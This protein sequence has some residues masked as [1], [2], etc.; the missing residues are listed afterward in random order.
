[1][2]ASKVIS[3]KFRHDNSSKKTLAYIGENLKMQKKF[4]YRN[5]EQYIVQQGKL[6]ADAF[7]KQYEENQKKRWSEMD[8]LEELN[9]K[10]GFH[11]FKENAMDIIYFIFGLLAT[12]IITMYDDIKKEFL[13]NK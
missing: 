10:K 13:G 8:R 12:P 7:R 3:S 11:R 6:R 5:S 2:N 1:M 4:A 9:K